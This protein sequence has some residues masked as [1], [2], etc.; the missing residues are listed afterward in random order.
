M[1]RKNFFRNKEKN[2]LLTFIRLW[3]I[4]S[5]K[6]KR[7]C[8]FLLI[9]MITTA[10]AELF[11]L[12]AVI[13][14]LG[15]L[16]NPDK[17]WSY[18]YVQNLA[19]FL[20]L[21]SS[22]SLIVPAT[23]FFSFAILLA[24]LVRLINL[25]FTQNLG[26]AIAS[27]LS[28]ESY[29]RTLFQP[30]EFHLSI[31]SSAVLTTSTTQIAKTQDLITSFLLLITSILIAISLFSGLLIIN[32]KMSIFSAFIISTS[33]YLLAKK[34]SRTLSNNSSV[35]ANL[36]ERQIKVMQEGLGSI[37]DV[38]LDGSQE[39]F[40]NIYR[41]S[42]LYMRLKMAQSIFLAQFPRYGFEAIG[43][44]LIAS[45]AFIASKDD[46]D[47]GGTITL[48]G[49]FALGAQR[50]LPA[51][52]QIYG[53]WAY[54][55]FNTSSADKVIQSC[56]KPILN[57]RGLKVNSKFRFRDCISLN[58]VSFCY[59][60]SSKNVLNNINLEIYKGEII[61]FIG[62][63]GS[64]KSTL[65]DI[66]MG[67]LSPNQGKIMVD[68]YDLYNC[69]NLDMGLLSSWRSNIAHVPQNIFLFDA[70]IAENIAFGIDKNN[71]DFEKVVQAA[72]LAQ[73]SQFI[74]SL[75][76]NYDTFVGERGIRLSGGQ[77]QRIAIARALYKKSNILV[78][79]EATSA[80]DSS[81]E[82]NLME[83]INNLNSDLTILMIAHRT[84][85]LKNCDRVYKVSSGIIKEE[86]DFLK[87]I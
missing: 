48:L 67:L 52:Q 69:K 70:S 33:Y 11:S 62:K 16:S 37:R 75:P 51:L 18:S 73:I 64:G 8:L 35:V 13:P 42:D 76:K 79:D 55:R 81:T 46:S 12:G 38:I 72:N 66:L 6:R 27:D 28:C 9:C 49:T 25:F 19:G 2:I 63:T 44:L 47:P 45:L 34:L 3:K 29:R 1:I 54:I 74:E 50:L 23:L 56:N 85:S 68:G 58:N 82:K 22:A 59:E 31:N 53:S 57:E 39:K 80:L 32:W 10:F 5:P 7:Q 26:A 60:S 65:I 4:M 84:S 24:A 20:G 30:Y 14:F 21:S 15:V 77:R 17:Y 36:S 71:I 61:G 87:N 78:F 41:K 86:Y 83:S 43:M 40:I